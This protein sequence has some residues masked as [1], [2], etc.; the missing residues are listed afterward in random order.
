MPTLAD[1]PEVQQV[2]SRPSPDPR[3]DAQRVLTWRVP[4]AERFR[5][6]NM[7]AG[8]DGENPLPHPSLDGLFASEIGI[9]L[10]GP[11]DPDHPDSCYVLI[12]VRFA[13]PDS[14]LMR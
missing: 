6:Y 7:V 9:E 1:F 13:E 3:V 12:E 5:F 8:V 10:D 2:D 4:Y 14:A 11:F